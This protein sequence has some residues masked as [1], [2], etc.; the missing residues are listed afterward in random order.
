MNQNTQHYWHFVYGIVSLTYSN[1]KI[2][3]LINKL[4]LFNAVTDFSDQPIWAISQGVD[5]VFCK[6]IG[7]IM[8]H[9][10][11]I[12]KQICISVTEFGMIYTV[13]WNTQRCLLSSITTSM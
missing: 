10:T 6:Y 7:S 13:I 9:F 11:A 12:I 2:T 3:M 8:L 4:P 5:S 1:I